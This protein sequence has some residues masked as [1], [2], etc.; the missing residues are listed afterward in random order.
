MAH[1]A[2]EE[3]QQA[4]QGRVGDADPVVAG[5]FEGLGQ[6]GPGRERHGQQEQAG[7]DEWDAHTGAHMSDAWHEKTS[8]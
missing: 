5:G 4:G 6:G 1:P 2:G 8:S 7:Q 3:Q